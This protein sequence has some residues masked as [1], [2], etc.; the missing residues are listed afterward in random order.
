[1]SEVIKPNL[2]F[3]YNGNATVFELA[4][5]AMHRYKKDPSLAEL[6]EES[7]VLS[8]AL[9]YDIDFYHR[10][11]FFIKFPETAGTELPAVFIKHG[12]TLERILSADVL[13]HIS[14][15][16][17]LQEKILEKINTRAD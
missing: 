10:E 13:N 16:Q 3:V 4:A 6:E 12:E 2:V 15:M 9:P 7:R 5:K 14:T 11:E 8:Q 1:M 17:E